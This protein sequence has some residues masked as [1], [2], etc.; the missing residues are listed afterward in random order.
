MMALAEAARDPSYPAEIVC[1]VSNRADAKGLEYA[2]AH[3]I[4]TRV[5]AHKDYVSREAF[6]RALNVY[7]QSKRCHIVAC[8]G[9]MRVM[10]GA[11]TEPWHGRMLNIHPSLLPA[12]PGLD[13][14]GRALADGAR[15]AGCT[16]HLV[17]GDLDGGPILAQAEVPVLEGDT[18]ETLAARILRQEHRIYPLALADLARRILLPIPPSPISPG[19]AAD[20]RRFR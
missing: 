12:Y 7:L 13:T 8:A 2:R 6:D 14:H 9:F 5:I 11:M 17:T 10:T 16:V 20:R 18:P 4:E 1:V 3:G 19:C 15:V